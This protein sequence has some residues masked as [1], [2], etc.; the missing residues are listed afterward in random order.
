MFVGIDDISFYTSG[1]YLS[2]S[3]LARQNGEDP[4]KYR[5]GLGQDRMGVPGPDEDAVTLAADA[6]WPLIN[7]ENRQRI[8]TVLFATE[9]GVDHSK[10][11]GIYVHK[12][13]GLRENCRI[14][15]LKQACYSATA[16]VQMACALVMRRPEDQVLVVASDIA[17]YG[18]GTPG[19][20]TQGC[21]AVAFIVKANPALLAVDTAYGCHSED[22]MDFW[23]PNHMD[24]A[25]VDGK[26]S[27]LV[28]LR[29]L[30]SSWQHYRHDGGQ[31]FT[32]LARFCYHLPFTRLAEKAHRKLASTEGQS[33]QGGLLD[34]QIAASLL[35]AR[36]TGNS[37]SASLYTALLSLLENDEDDLAGQRIGLFSYG[38]GCVGEFF[39]M[40]VQ[41]GY[42]KRSRR[43]LHL[44][45]LENR[46]ELEYADYAR[47][48]SYSLP[49]DGG[50][51]E[52]P[53]GAAGR[54]RLAALDKHKRI[55][56]TTG[57]QA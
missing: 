47:L 11:A 27:T 34:K 12:L 36:Q 15:E 2:L 50:Y 37:Y 8:S 44:G 42:K 6:A 10:S 23:R 43:A 38:S 18:L 55:Y 49:V 16:A 20:A 54:Y 51:H 3:S 30:V 32:D 48:F 4:E 40:Q 31:R 26:Y 57:T 1:K 22:V 45:L 39:S 35:Y 25:L 14:V 56:T 19:E 24:T 28:Y 13:I 21:G 29:A 9:S 17:R 46:Q 5:T 41:P 33:L 53:H 7:K 52:L